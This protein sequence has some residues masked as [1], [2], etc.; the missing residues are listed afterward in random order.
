[1]GFPG[2]FVWDARGLR[3]LLACAEGGFKRGAFFRRKWDDCHEPYCGLFVAVCGY[4]VHCEWCDWY[5]I[6]RRVF[7]KVD[8]N[9]SGSFSLGIHF[10]NFERLDFSDASTGLIFIGFRGCWG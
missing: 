5:C 4:T 7:E 3:D 2:H 1:V 10:F 9:I 8:T 6:G